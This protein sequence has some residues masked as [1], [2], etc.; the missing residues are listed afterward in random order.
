MGDVI[1]EVAKGLVR[2]K[3]TLPLGCLLFLLTLAGIT[4]APLLFSG[5]K[6]AYNIAED[7]KRRSAPIST[8]IPEPRDYRLTPTVSYPIPTLTPISSVPPEYISF[9]INRISL[10]HAKT[11]GVALITDRW[12]GWV[13]YAVPITCVQG[14]DSDAINAGTISPTIYLRPTGEKFGFIP[15]AACP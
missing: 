4:G 6:T 8:S 15:K 10:D 11:D 12:A 5:A 13:Y 2:E 1:K 3:V 7:K 14:L 9:V